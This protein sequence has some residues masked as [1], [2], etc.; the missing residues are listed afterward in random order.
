MPY[1]IRPRRSLTAIATCGA[2]LLL[3]AGSALAAKS[4]ESGST[5]LTSPSQCTEP[6]LYQ[7]FLGFG[8]SS[9]YALPAGESYDNFS[10]KGWVLSGGATFMQTRLY[11]GATGYVLDMPAN[12]TATSPSFC[13]NPEYPKARTMIA[14]VSGPPNLSFYVTYASS[15]QSPSSNIPAP[16]GNVWQL[17]PAFSLYP[18][19]TPGWQLGK[20]TF[21]AG[22]NA[23]EVRLYNFY[24]DP[25]KR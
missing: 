10:G 24:V 18:S 9:Y 3:G 20:F 23:S 4:K 13:L 22:S 25:Y 11:D 17:S 6:T 7:P 14:D 1:I 5:Q 2:L 8:D 21:V 16:T 12:S 19:A 15:G